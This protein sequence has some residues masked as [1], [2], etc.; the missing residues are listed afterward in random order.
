MNKTL[1]ILL[2]TTL[3][4]FHVKG[5]DVYYDS[6]TLPPHLH[7]SNN[8]L[9]MRTSADGVKLDKVKIKVDVT[10]KEIVLSAKALKK[11]NFRW[12]TR[13]TFDL[14]RY[15]ITDITSFNVYWLNPDNSKIPLTVY[16]KTKP[17][18]TSSIF[19]FREG[20]KWFYVDSNFNKLS[21]EFDFIYPFYH[22]YAVVQIN[23]KYALINKAMMLL[24]QPVFDEISYQSY[25]NDLKTPYFDV[26]KDKKQFRVDTTGQ[27][28]RGYVS[29]LRTCGGSNGG[30]R[31]FNTYKLNGKVG[32]IREYDY[33]FDTI[34][35]AIYD[36]ITPIGTQPTH[37][38][39]RIGEKYGVI[40][41]FKGKEKLPIIYDEIRIGRYDN[42]YYD[43]DKEMWVCIDNKCG[44]VDRTFQALTELK[45][46]DGLPFKLGFSLVQTTDGKWGYID[47]QGKEYWR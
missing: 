23:N 7:F 17:Y 6:I 1:L 29:Y 47:R 28:F 41:I 25:Y 4:A 20:D 19:P 24:T 31:R 34:T 36:A 33:P 35:P 42:R 15:K 10:Q 45:Y 12:K 13:H 39:V 37:F 8:V 46:T 9:E 11:E 27:E 14:N 2:I 3:F 44:F 21:D 38:I 5:Q 43:P 30:F 18:Y 26:T 16:S 32:L 22:N 40:D